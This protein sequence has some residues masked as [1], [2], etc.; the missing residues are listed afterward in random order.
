MNEDESLNTLSCVSCSNTKHSTTWRRCGL[1][2]DL[3]W[4]NETCF[5]E[6]ISVHFQEC[7]SRAFDELKIAIAVGETFTE[8]QKEK[9]LGSD[10]ASRKRM[11]KSACAHCKQDLWVWVPH[12][13]LKAEENRT[14]A[15]L[16]IHVQEL[17]GAARDQLLASA[18][19]G[20]TAQQGEVTA[21]TRRLKALDPE[22]ASRFRSKLTS[23]SQLAFRLVQPLFLEFREKS[24]TGTPAQER[25]DLPLGL[26]KT[27]MSWTHRDAAVMAESSSFIAISYSWHSPVWA[28]AESLVDIKSPLTLP[29]WR[30]IMKLRS[31]DKEGIWID[32]LSIKQDDE[33]DKQNAIAAMDLI[34]RSA[35]IV[36]V[37]L[38]DICLP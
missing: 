29:M 25:F 24:F 12:S 35:R 32:Q 7:F 28:L 4:C 9:V 23:A 33:S 2:Y 15:S 1:C 5:E 20:L 13:S 17:P 22:V 21:L 30:K 11:L 27:F 37:V 16:I 36:V 3:K 38:E 6:G 10:D 8:I 34:Y 31:S 26:A 14:T 19:E 18:L